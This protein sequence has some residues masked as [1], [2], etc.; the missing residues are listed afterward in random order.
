MNSN[1]KEKGSS[2]HSG[3][4]SWAVAAYTGLVRCRLTS[5]PSCMHWPAKLQTGVTAL[6][7]CTGPSSQVA[8]KCR[9]GTSVSASRVQGRMA[10]K[11][12]CAVRWLQ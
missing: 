2:H 7:A 4:C 3:D 5:L 8:A 12:R 9:G 10:A 6:A 1:N 11:N